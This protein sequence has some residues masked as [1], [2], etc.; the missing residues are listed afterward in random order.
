MSLIPASGDYSVFF[1]HANGFSA[2]VYQ[3]FLR[4]LELKSVHSIDQLGMSR[5]GIGLH[6]QGI[7]QE[8]ADYVIQLPAPRIGIGHSLGAFSLY[9]AE[10][11]NPGL[12]SAMVLLEPPMFRPL[13]RKQID[14]LRFLGLLDRFPPV[15]QAK[16]RTRVWSSRESAAIH[17]RSRKLFAN[18]D[19]EC[20]ND[21]IQFGLKEKHLGKSRVETSQTGGIANKLKSLSTETTLV[22]PAEIEYEI[23]KNGPPPVKRLK[24]PVPGWIL[25]GEQ[26]DV[27]KPADIQYIGHRLTGFELLP[28]PGGHLFPLERPENTAKIIRQLLES[29]QISN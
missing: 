8:I 15:S 14:L 7:V 16:N 25:F 20:M 27:L 4:Y 10:A 28:V 29:D 22:I 23:F 2:P 12:F 11:N 1:G 9:L 26:T 6:W 3:K 13:L 21:F 24:K 17:L 5:Y 18:I 19:P